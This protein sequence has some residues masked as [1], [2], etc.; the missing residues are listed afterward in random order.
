MAFGKK[1]ESVKIEKSPL[2]AQSL[3]PAQ[4]ISSF[5]EQEQKDKEKKAQQEQLKALA[6]TFDALMANIVNSTYLRDIPEEK[7]LNKA[8]IKSSGFSMQLITVLDHYMPEGKYDHPLIGLGVSAMI[9][10]SVINAKKPIKIKK[11]PKNEPKKEITGTSGETHTTGSSHAPAA[12][13]SPASMDP[14]KI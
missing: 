11:K 9:L 6:G 7:Q 12:A 3:A 14:G 13:F 10:G 1:K 2:P 8:D 5:H 4:P